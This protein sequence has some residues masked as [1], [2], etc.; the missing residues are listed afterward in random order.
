MPWFISYPVSKA[1][2][3]HYPGQLSFQTYTTQH[4]KHMLTH[5]LHIIK[6]AGKHA[7]MHA[8]YRWIHKL[9]VLHTNYS[10]THTHTGIH[11]EVWSAGQG[12]ESLLCEKTPR[13]A[14]RASQGNRLF[15]G[16]NP[17]QPS[18]HLCERRGRTRRRREASKWSDENR[19][20]PLGRHENCVEGA[21]SKARA[22][23][24]ENNMRVQGRVKMW[25]L[26]EVAWRVGGKMKVK[27]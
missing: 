21:R 14:N 10:Q 2:G 7:Q 8:C 23:N 17:R 6:E 24:G 11:T 25:V 26:G 18:S 20:D 15:Q 1:F 9:G 5:M 27:N 12:R 16:Q 3:T 19:P 13:K 4:C 22:R